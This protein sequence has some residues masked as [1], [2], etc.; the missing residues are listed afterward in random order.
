MTHPWSPDE[1]IRRLTAQ[2]KLGTTSLKVGCLSPRK[3]SPVTVS[4]VRRRSLRWRGPHSPRPSGPE[5]V[6]PWAP[7]EGRSSVPGDRSVLLPV[8]PLTGAGVRTTQRYANERFDE[9][10]VRVLGLRL[11]CEGFHPWVE[12]TLGR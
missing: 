9:A 3:D 4:K 10:N 7:V 6:L 1:I 5:T 12:E 8:P 11:S 2:R